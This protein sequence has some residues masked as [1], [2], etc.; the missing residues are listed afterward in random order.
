[1]VEVAESADYGG[2]IYALTSDTDYV[3]VGGATTQTVKKLRKTDMVEVAESAD[4]GG[5][6][7]ASLTQDD[8]Y[9]YVGGFTTWT[10]KK[11]QKSDLAEVAESANYGGNIRALT[12][13]TDYVYVSGSVTRTVKKLQKSDLAEVAESANYGGNI[14]DL[15]SDDDYVYAGG[16]T[17]QTVKKLQKSDMVEVA[18]SANYG[19]VIY[20]LTQDDDYVYVSG[21]TTQTVK[22]L[23]KTSL[24]AWYEPNDIISGTTL[25]DRAGTSQDGTFSWGS[26]PAGVT[27]TLGSMASS[28][29][30]SIG[31]G[32]TDEAVDVLEE[33]AV[34]DWFIDPNLAALADNPLRPFVTIMSDTTT[35]TELQA[36]RLLGLAFVLFVAVATIVTVR[37]HLLIAGIATGASILVLVVWTIWP[38]WALV[39]V[40]GCV[41]AGII[42]ERSPS[43]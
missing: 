21:A 17:T 27:V 38:M 18:E 33:V 10:V 2:V 39:F 4:Y 43:I 20:A 3:Y 42:A 23:Q 31:V 5:I 9:V 1:M 8:D 11:L 35:L 36:W 29:Q 28:G 41:L 24:V 14:E 19:G 13:D 32:V 25:P 6:I 40:A 7:Y 30:P 34:S 15:I 26:N 12:S 22:K 37:R 16:S